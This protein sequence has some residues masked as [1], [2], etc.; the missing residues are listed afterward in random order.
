M[1]T[2]GRTK[3]RLLPE[4]ALN[5]GGTEGE[6]DQEHLASISAELAWRGSA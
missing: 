5:P 4:P 6:S 1:L 3:P 2:R